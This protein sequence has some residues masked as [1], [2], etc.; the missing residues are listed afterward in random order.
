MLDYGI[1]GNCKTC[2]LVSRRASIDWFCFPTFDSPSVF[3]KLLDKKKGGYFSIKT[4]G[5]YRVTQRYIGNTNVLETRFS[6]KSAE[7]TVTDFFP[8][9]KKLLP[10]KRTTVQK[11]N[12]LVRIIKPVRGKPIIKI[13]YDPRL[14]Y[15][16]GKSTTRAF[17]GNLVTRNHKMNMHL[18]SNLDYDIITHKLFFKLDYTRYFVLG[19][20]NDSSRYS[21]AF[22]SKLMS[23]TK[24]YW[25]QWVSTLIIPNNNKELIIRSALVLKLLTFSETGAIIA[26]A[27]TSIP[28]EIGAVRNWDYRFCWVR[29]AVFTV[30]AFKKIGRDYEAKRLMEFIASIC[31]DKKLPFQIMY[32]INRE[33]KLTEKALPHLHGFANSRPVRVGNA[34]YGQ[35]Q[36]DI[37]GT[38]IDLLYLYF[39]YYQYEPKMTKRFWDLLLTLVKNIERNWRKR[40]AGIWEFRGKR[41]HFTYSKLMCYVGMDRAARIAQF[42]RKWP[43]AQEWISTRD[44]I[45]DDICKKGWKQELGAFS[46]DYEEPFLDAS[47]LQMCYHNFLQPDDPRIIG[48]V[49]TID[50]ELRKEVYVQRYRV[51]DDFGK[52]HSAFTVCTFWL[53]DA[54]VYIG[55]AKLA[56]QIF[57]RIVK[58]SNHLG[59]FSEDL[60]M[61]NGRMLGNMPQAYCHTA[62]INSAILLSEWSAKRKKLDK[63]RL[64]GLR[65]R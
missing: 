57:K 48:T 47:V 5:I 6:S 33:T 46:M 40:D 14:N 9:Y 60:D 55:K 41:R 23:A 63:S 21:V 11:E 43:L 28:E 49:K 59:L 4:K 39:V 32:G 25:Q 15:S 31:V 3:A 29:D 35:K 38:A 58:K 34:A 20:N 36:N 18:V 26:A 30:D 16:L 54:L 50:R 56:R 37:F 1:I 61:K 53:I 42:Y 64:N 13:A 51:N 44:K 62:V 8:R 7:F 10:N 24:K 2:A 12:R 22:C 17:K 52:S 27:T 65:V 45:A 19:E